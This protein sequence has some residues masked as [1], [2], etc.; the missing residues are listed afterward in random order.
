MCS[1]QNSVLRKV[2]FGLCSCHCSTV[3]TATVFH[4]LSSNYLTS[5]HIVNKW[6]NYCWTPNISLIVGADL[7][8]WRRQSGGWI[9]VVEWAHCTGTPPHPFPSVHHS[10]WAC[11]SRTPPVDGCL[12]TTHHPCTTWWSSKGSQSRG[13]WW[14]CYGLPRLW[15]SA[16]P[17]YLGNLRGTRSKT[18]RGREGE[19]VAG[20]KQ[21]K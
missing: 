13:S 5:V 2:I 20:R 7:S 15:C 10:A 12:A 14:K 16:W 3:F 6:I 17:G 18:E 1:I 4:K 19:G 11:H 8:Q 21:V 9:S